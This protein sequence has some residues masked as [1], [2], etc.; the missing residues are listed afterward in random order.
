MELYFQCILSRLEDDKANCQAL[1][2]STLS[3]LM[4]FPDSFMDINLSS[5]CIFPLLPRD[6]QTSPCWHVAQFMVVRNTWEEFWLLLYLY[7]LT[8]LLLSAFSFLVSRTYW[9][10]ELIVSFS[11]FEMGPISKH[12]TEIP[13]DFHLSELLVCES[14][15]FIFMFNYA[16]IN[17][18]YF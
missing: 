18:S 7:S 3:S 4:D 8:C 15:L 1:H 11:S 16:F 6:R 5:A 17:L 12:F 10:E 9:N 2:L 14:F 13:L